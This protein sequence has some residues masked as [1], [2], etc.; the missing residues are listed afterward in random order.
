MTD[1]V[2]IRKA[3]FFRQATIDGRTV[4]RITEADGIWYRMVNGR[5]V[6]CASF[7][8]AS[9]WFSLTLA[10]AMLSAGLTVAD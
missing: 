3:S 2:Q 8:A 4:A 10:A 6:A 5:D 9:T 1:R 7:E